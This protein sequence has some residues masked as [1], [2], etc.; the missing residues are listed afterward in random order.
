MV[1]HCKAHIGEVAVLES[2]SVAGL[3]D[4]GCTRD[5]V[6]RR[7]DD[8]EEEEGAGARCHECGRLVTGSEWTTTHVNLN[9]QH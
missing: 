1:R 4:G 7:M 6:T 2:R 3:E 5:M 9:A 8:G